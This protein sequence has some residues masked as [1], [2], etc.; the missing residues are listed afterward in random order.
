MI[1]VEEVTGLLAGGL[2]D[3][4]AA[5]VHGHELRDVVDEVVDDRPN[6]VWLRCVPGDLFQ[7]DGRQTLNVE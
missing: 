1:P 3:F 5:R 4:L 6:S 2:E 7:R